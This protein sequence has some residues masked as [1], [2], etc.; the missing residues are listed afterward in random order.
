MWQ[1]VP[2]YVEIKGRNKNKTR[3]II[4]ENLSITLGGIV[5]IKE[6]TKLNLIYGKKYGLIGRNGLGKSVL[7]RKILICS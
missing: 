7:L 4:V 6:G 2:W 1:D 5:L 3:D